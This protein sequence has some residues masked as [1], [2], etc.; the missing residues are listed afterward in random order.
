MKVLVFNDKSTNRPKHIV[1]KSVKTQG[2]GKNMKKQGPKPCIL[3]G[4]RE[5]TLS[6]FA[7]YDT[8]ATLKHVDSKKNL[9]SPEGYSGSPEAQP[10][11]TPNKELPTNRFRVW[12][13]SD[14]QNSIP[15]SS[16]RTDLDSSEVLT[17]RIRFPRP[18]DEQI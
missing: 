15:E 9:L 13:A 3:R 5:P 12:K 4:L 14:E 2:S 10:T 8:F 1:K 6:S 11:S 16:R 17:S 7:K 18:P